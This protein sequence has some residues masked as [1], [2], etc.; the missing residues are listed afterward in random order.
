M[1]NICTGTVSYLLMMT[2]NEK[3]H[4]KNIMISSALALIIGAVAI[5]YIGIYGA[6]IMVCFALITTNMTSWYIVKKKLGIN[7]LQIF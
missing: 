1:V 2:G 3:S 5:T 6:L 4:M 7:T